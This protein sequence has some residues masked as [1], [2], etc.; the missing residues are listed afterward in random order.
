MLAAAAHARRGDAED[1]G[2]FRGAGNGEKIFG[3]G[4]RLRQVADAARAA[5]GRVGPLAGATRF[6]AEAPHPARRL[7][8]LNAAC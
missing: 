3:D 1:L 2:R 7:A 6:K 8:R 5:L 4:Q